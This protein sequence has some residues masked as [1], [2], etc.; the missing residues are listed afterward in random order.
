MEAYEAPGMIKDRRAGANLFQTEDLAKN[1][2]ALAERIK[3]L[4]CLYAVS[5]ALDACEGE[6]SPYFAEIVQYIPRG[7][8]F[9]EIVSARIRVGDDVHASHDGDPEPERCLTRPI[10]LGD[11]AVGALEIWYREQPPGEMLFLPEEESLI[12]ALAERLSETVRRKHAEKVLSQSEG[13]F[14]ALVENNADLICVLNSDGRVKYASPAQSRLLGRIIHDRLFLDILHPEEVSEIGEAL[15][16]LLREPDRSVALSLRLAHAN[17]SWRVFEA[18]M[19]NMVHDPA[20]AGIVVNARDIT[21]RQQLELR[22][23]EA[24]KMEAIGRLAGGIAHDFN[25]ILTTIIGFAS[26]L[27]AYDPPS[28]RGREDLIEIER[29]AERA[30]GLTRQLLAFSRRQLLQPRTLDIGVLIRELERML[31]RLIGEHIEFH[32]SIDPDLDAVRAD[33]SQLQQV[34]LNLTVN[35]RDAMPEGGTLWIRARNSDGEKRLPEG[36]YVEI[37]VSD[38]GLGMTD[39]VRGHVFEPFFS[40]KPPGIGTGLGLS[41][42]FGVVSQSGGVVDVQSAPGKGSRFRVWLPS[43]GRVMRSERPLKM[44]SPSTLERPVTILLVEDDASV[45]RL[46]RRLLESRGYRVREAEDGVEAL[47]TLEQAAPLDLIL[48]DVVMPR[49]NGRQLVERAAV[50]RPELPVLMMSGYTD[51]ELVRAGVAHGPFLHKPFA[52]EDLFEKVEELVHSAA[53]GHLLPA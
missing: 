3:E 41:T 10:M 37:E 5:R 53:R 13:W 1:D 38:T 52:P 17:G 49:M 19:R 20:V 47:L 35:A 29:A 16:N 27:L 36:R 15:A 31:V 48:T 46:I 24:Q 23:V 42:V 51:D 25:N 4:T 11:E 33:E 30:A 2:R 8:Q 18:T 9:P 28:G 22:L 34:I 43:I 40:T 7:W 32:T 50:I 45:R 21:E 6:L 26:L 14:R 44:S 39:E 12:S